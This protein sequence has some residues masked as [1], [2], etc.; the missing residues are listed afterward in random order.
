M[1][2]VV[3]RPQTGARRVVA[4]PEPIPAT[5]TVDGVRY[6]YQRHADPLEGRPW[7]IEAP[8][9]P[10][11]VRLCMHGCGTCEQVELCGQAPCR[12][13]VGRT[14]RCAACR[15]VSGL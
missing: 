3:L 4:V 14:Q 2:E 7:Y 6:V 5:P 15:A 11:L 10:P 9:A 1:L 12:I 13:G 8:E